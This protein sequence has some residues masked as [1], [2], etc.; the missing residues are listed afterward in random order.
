MTAAHR[1]GMAALPR[2][3]VLDLPD[4][5]SLAVSRGGFGDISQFIFASTP[6]AQL[7]E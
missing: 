4:G 6:E 3:M 2:R 5:R 7:A 1:A